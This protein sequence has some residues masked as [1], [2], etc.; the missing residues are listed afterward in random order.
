VKTYPYGKGKARW[1]STPWLADHLDEEMLA[2]IDAQPSVHD[3]IMEHIPGATYMTE[4]LLRAP[5]NGIPVHYVPPEAIQPVLR[6]LGLKTDTPVVVYTGKGPIKKGG[7]GLEQTA[8]AYGLVRFGHNNVYILDGGIDKWKAEGRPLTKVYPQVDESNFVVQVQRDYFVEYDEFK[9]MVGRDDVLLVDSRP[10]G[11]YQ[12]QF[13]RS[14]PGHIPGSIN[15]PWDT[16]MDI[17]NPR[18]LL[19]DDEIQALLEE[20]EITPD[21]TIV[22]F[23]GTG[24]K[25]TN[26]FLL[27]KWY[28]GFPDV[29]IFEGSFTEWVAHPENPTV[30]GDEPCDDAVY[31][32]C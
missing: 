14:K 3:Y 24:R 19:P 16:F 11:V 22:C 21:K 25:A 4:G 9:T 20:Y 27:F 23:C 5:L 29:R 13:H 31:D 17:D 10:M 15:V 2:I 12:G 30:V 8:V 18:L 28:L 6:R 26:Q 7:D 32:T 1:V